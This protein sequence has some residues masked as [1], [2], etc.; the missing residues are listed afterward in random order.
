MHTNARV[1]AIDH[2]LGR[3][4]YYWDYL[5]DDT[6]RTFVEATA[7]P[8]HPGRH[9]SPESVLFLGRAPGPVLP[10]TPAVNSFSPL[11]TAP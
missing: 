9:V 7:D 1:P 8:I 5:G 2:G 11:S 4:L 6:M 3:L 10:G